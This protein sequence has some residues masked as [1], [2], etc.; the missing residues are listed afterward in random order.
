MPTTAVAALASTPAA[1]THSSV[2]TTVLSTAQDVVREVTS[3]AAMGTSI[4]GNFDDTTSVGASFPPTTGMKATDTLTSIE[5]N[6]TTTLLPSESTSG[7]LLHRNG[8]A[9]P[10][11]TAAASVIDNESAAVTAAASGGVT[12]PITGTATTG[13]TTD[14]EADHHTNPPPTTVAATVPQT[15]DAAAGPLTTDDGPAVP[16]ATDAAP[17]P[18]T[19]DA[20]FDAAIEVNLCDGYPC[21]QKHQPE[22]NQ[23][24]MLSLNAPLVVEVMVK[25]DHATSI[26]SYTYDFRRSG[27]QAPI[28]SR[29][30][31]TNFAQFEPSELL[32]DDHVDGLEYSLSIKVTSEEG[33]HAY[34]KI[35]QIFFAPAPRLHAINVT[36]LARNSSSAYFEHY[37]VSVNASTP[38]AGQLWFDYWISTPSWSMDIV[39]MHEATATISAPISSE[40]MTL[41]VRAT[42]AFKSATWCVQNASTKSAG[43]IVCPGLVGPSTMGASAQTILDNIVDV[44]SSDDVGANEL[45]ALYFGGLQLIQNW[46]DTSTGPSDDTIT[47]LVDNFGTYVESSSST[48]DGDSST[49]SQNIDLLV[50]FVSVLGDYANDTAQSNSLLNATLAIGASLGTSLYDDQSLYAFASAIDGVAGSS[51]TD[52]TYSL[53]DDAVESM[54]G[55]LMLGDI[56]GT[57]VLLSQEHTSMSCSVIA[58]GEMSAGLDD[59]DAGLSVSVVVPPHSNSSFVVSV[60]VWGL[61]SQTNSSLLS[62][63]QSVSVVGSDGSLVQSFDDSVQDGGFEMSINVAVTDNSTTTALRRQLR[64]TFWENGEWSSR[65]VVLLGLEVFVNIDTSTNS[66]DGLG[67]AALCLTSHLS[68][69]TVTDE[70]AL[71]DKVED[72][73][74]SLST[75]ISQLDDVNLSEAGSVIS[76]PILVFFG[77]AS[78]I[79][80]LTIVITKLRARKTAAAEAKRVF[81]RFGVLERPQIIGLHEIDSIVRCYTTPKEAWGLIALDIVTVNPLL[82]PFFAWSHEAIVYNRSDKAFILYSQIMISC[83]VMSLFMDSGVSAEEVAGNASWTSDVAMHALLDTLMDIFVQSFV[84]QVLLAPVKYFLPFMISNVNSIRS[85]AGDATR[86][87][88]GHLRSLMSGKR[89]KKVGARH[90]SIRRSGAKQVQSIVVDKWQKVCGAWH[91]PSELLWFLCSPSN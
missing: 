86:N 6:V 53:L 23:T 34:G 91:A 46:N 18:R 43:S 73:F 63:I 57:N 76:Y 8:T 32:S 83:I 20:T 33:E 47:A 2:T 52:E 31:Q 16:R 17:V 77:V 27:E 11:T 84:A 89:S 80:L 69:F 60:T 54:C 38:D 10:S 44:T 29:T 85:A 82:A 26:Q 49:V 58:P 25:S 37:A 12:Q 39:G 64:C 19:T 79:F 55:S 88:L 51:G 90:R 13:T 65:G 61:E 87:F 22:F 71:V 7:N 40:P 74:E 4:P 24:Y 62:N 36:A 67:V 59:A 45:A 68:T 78:T 3:S 72:Q 50:A 70:S 30:S 75:R 5:S 42:N 1:I 15:T 81:Q 48:N 21:E 35:D 41:H 56:P 14:D 28:V 66:P 9:A